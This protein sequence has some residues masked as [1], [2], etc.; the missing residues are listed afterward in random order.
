M[1]TEKLLA[2]RKTNQSIASAPVAPA[3]CGIFGWMGTMDRA[4]AG[5]SSTIGSRAQDVP[6][7]TCG[8][9]FELLAHDCLKGSD[10]IIG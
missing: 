4:P 9:T 6:K 3:S 1:A 5:G 10:F 7:L 2:C 8:K